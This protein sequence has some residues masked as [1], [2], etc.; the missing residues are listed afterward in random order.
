[1][2]AP[3]SN[4]SCFDRL[5]T[6]SVQYIR[7]SIQN[8][9]SSANFEYL[10]GRAIESRRQHQPDLPP[11][12]ECIINLTQFT[13]GYE[14]LVLELAFSDHVYWVAR[15]PHQSIQRDTI[16]SEIATMKVVRE[17]TSIP[18]PQVFCFEVSADQPFGYPYI[19]MEALDGRTFPDGLATAIPAQHRAKVAKQL[20]NVFAELQNLTFSR[21]GRLW[22]GDN[23]DEPVKVVKMAWHAL[24]GPLETS[25]EYFYHHI[26]E[27]N[28]HVMYRMHPGDPD[29]STACWV[30][31]MSLAH[32]IIEDRV[33][34]PFPL[35]HF[36]LQSRNMLFDDEYNLTGLIDWTCA[37]AAPLEQLSVFD[38]FFIW[39]GISLELK[40]LVI[41]SLR[42]MER[43]R[44]E[45]PPLDNPGMDMTPYQDLTTLSEYM[46]S[47]G[48]EITY[49]HF[50]TSI[51]QSLL[52]GKVVAEIMHGNAITWEQLREVYGAMPLSTVLA[53]SS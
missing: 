19:L 41:E 44:E 53:E 45:R 3:S 42:E 51:Q 16:L 34:G 33:R 13:S 32:V 7:N 38:E 43:D 22:C 36:G 31:K 11:H 8:I 46:T 26:Q 10:R 29:W 1:M 12:L 20:A 9:L 37:Q 23:A 27:Q 24:P 30:L 6:G 25:L 21:I 15:I 2:K 40:R 18:V 50:T 39:G 28:Q 52:A 5:H 48:A 47:M 4:W 35:I 17:R 49:H 14:H